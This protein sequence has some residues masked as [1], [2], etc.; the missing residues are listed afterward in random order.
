MRG[1]VFIHAFF[2]FFAKGKRRKEEE[3]EEEEGKCMVLSFEGIVETEG[4]AGEEEKA[5]ERGG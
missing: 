5:R 2:P 4:W 3:E 1:I